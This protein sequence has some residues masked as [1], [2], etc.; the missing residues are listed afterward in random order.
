MQVYLPK[1]DF[2]TKFLAKYKVASL[3]L[4]ISNERCHG[5]VGALKFLSYLRT[6]D[7]ERII[8]YVDRGM[9]VFSLDRR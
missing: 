9:F 7:P 3:P 8:P 5:R 4:P 2:D 6:R 1:L